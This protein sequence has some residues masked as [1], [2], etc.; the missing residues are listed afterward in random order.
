V[1]RSNVGDVSVPP[2]PTAPGSSDDEH[3]SERLRGPVVLRRERR[4]EL[5]TTDQRLL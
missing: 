4:Q 1:A 2:N 3:P 5:T